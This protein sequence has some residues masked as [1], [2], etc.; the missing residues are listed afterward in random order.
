MNYIHRVEYWGGLKYNELERKTGLKNNMEYLLANSVS[1]L[2]KR[3]D[4]LGLTD[5]DKIIIGTS[6]SLGLLTV[7]LAIVTYLRFSRLHR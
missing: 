4:L 6:V 5:K 2:V 3:S 1:E 7:I